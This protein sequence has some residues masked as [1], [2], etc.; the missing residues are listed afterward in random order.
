MNINIYACC[1]YAITIPMLSKVIG[2]LKAIR[3]CTWSRCKHWRRLDGRG[4]RT[5]RSV[6]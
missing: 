6:V 5:F 1:I 3:P 2:S 4:T